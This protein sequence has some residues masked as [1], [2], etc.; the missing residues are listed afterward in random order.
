MLLSLEL[1]LPGV[2]LYT[3]AKKAGTR[4]ADHCTKSYW[5]FLAVK[6]VID[7]KL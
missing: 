2:E 4:V 1:Y 5:H 3:G 7:P 6:D